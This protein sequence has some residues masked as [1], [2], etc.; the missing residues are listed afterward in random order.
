MVVELAVEQQHVVAFVVGGFDIVVLSC[1][2]GGIEID[3][4]AFGI[5]LRGFDEG[6]VLIKCIVMALGILEEHKFHGSV[7][8][9]LVGKHAVD[10]KYADVVPFLFK[11]GAVGAEKLVETAGYLLGDVARYL[12]DSGICLKVRA[13]HVER[14]VGRVDYTLEQLHELRHYAFYRIGNEY[15]VAVE[16]YAVAVDVEVVFDFGEIE[17]ACQVEG[18]VH[19]EVNP[20]ERLFLAGIKLL[21]ESKIIGIGKLAGFLHPLGLGAVDYKVA[22]GIGPCAVFPFALLATDYRHGQEAAIFAKQGVDALLVKEFLAVVVDVEYDVGTAGRTRACPHRVLGR[23]VA[24]PAHS[25]GA[26]LVRQ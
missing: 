18:V 10:D 13:R 12:L 8:E 25:L 24:L 14:D 1:G 15:L 7:A 16:L 11:F 3:Y 17:D 22:V 26:V 4:A 9:F 19:V 23:T 2:I 5:G 21:V 20:E 6:L